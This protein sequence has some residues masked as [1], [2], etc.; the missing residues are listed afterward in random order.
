MLLSM[1]IT[2]LHF[3]RL[4]WL[5]LFYDTKGEKLG[6]RGII[7]VLTRGRFGPK[8]E[9]WSSFH[10]SNIDTRRFGPSC[11][12]GNLTALACSGG[13][14]SRANHSKATGPV[15][16]NKERRKRWGRLFHSERETISGCHN[17]INISLKLKLTEIV[18]ESGS[19]VRR[20]RQKQKRSREGDCRVVCGRS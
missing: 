6:W 4:T 7:W 12:G 8:T 5:L 3:D 18:K 1:K 9:Q 19:D 14:T 16:C 17:D 2:A 10:L 15:L 20:C 13:S 11:T